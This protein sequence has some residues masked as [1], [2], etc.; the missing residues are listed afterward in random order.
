MITV[1]PEEIT[2]FR[3]QFADNPEAS[4]ALDAIAECEGYVEDA[5][6]LI[7]M[8]ETAREAD[9]SLNDWL[10]KCRQFICQE[11]VRDALESG[12]IAPVVEPLAMSAGI[13][14]GT[15]TALSVLVFKLG[16]KKFCKTPESGV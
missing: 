2:Q 1:T 10:E 6:P 12:L 5:V 14:V 15:A 4:A 9:R 8:R 3:S 13:P 11:D 7:F 16:A